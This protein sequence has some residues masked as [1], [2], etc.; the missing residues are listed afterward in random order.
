MRALPIAVF[1]RR[2]ACG[3]DLTPGMRACCKCRARH[4]WHRRKQ[5]HDG[6]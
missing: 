6:I 5:R 3:A 2:C 4:R 1:G